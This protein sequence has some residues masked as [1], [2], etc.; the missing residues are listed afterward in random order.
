MFPNS[1]A[2]SIRSECF[3]M[4]HTQSRLR[5]KAPHIGFHPC[6]A[7][8]DATLWSCQVRRIVGG[9]VPAL[10][11]E[12]TWSDAESLV[13]WNMLWATQF[14]GC[15]GILLST[16]EIN[17][18]IVNHCLGQS[19]EDPSAWNRWLMPGSSWWW[20]PDAFHALGHVD[21]QASC[22]Q[23]MNCWRNFWSSLNL[24]MM[25]GGVLPTVG[26][27]I[28]KTVKKSQKTR[29]TL[30]R[31]D[32]SVGWCHH[33]RTPRPGSVSHAA[34][35]VQR[36]PWTLERHEQSVLMWRMWRCNEVEFRMIIEILEC[37]GWHHGRGSFVLWYKESLMYMPASVE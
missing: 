21:S 3:K 6:Q 12:G 34:R 5:P 27:H 23:D 26:R 11:S 15:F 24:W 30:K 20:T 31:L 9:T 8:G 22:R 33:Q 28:L 4:W 32:D 14:W 35:S 19:H 2:M 10:G 13:L 17:H 36:W 16:F 7:R 37:Y 1:S 18:Q 25:T 29:A